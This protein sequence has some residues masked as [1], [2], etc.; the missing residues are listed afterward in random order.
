MLPA[1]HNVMCIHVRIRVC[2]APYSQSWI[3]PEK[4]PVEERGKEN[5]VPVRLLSRERPVFISVAYVICNA[6]ILYT[7]TLPSCHIDAKSSQRKNARLFTGIR[8]TVRYLTEAVYTSF[9]SSWF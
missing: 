1:S 3:S 5:I 7:L 8:C 2:V 4:M 6:L 9:Q